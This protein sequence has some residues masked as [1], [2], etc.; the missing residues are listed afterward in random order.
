MKIKKA[1]LSRVI[2]KLFQLLHDGK[3]LR[4]PRV[5]HLLGNMRKR[6]REEVMRGD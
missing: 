2:S 5:L 3:S 6:I 4:D 1:S